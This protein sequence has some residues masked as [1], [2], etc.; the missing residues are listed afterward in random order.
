[1]GRM[2]EGDPRPA[3][4]PVLIGGTSPGDWNTE[5]C[6]CRLSTDG[7]S[8]HPHLSVG[9]WFPPKQGR[10]PGKRKAWMGFRKQDSHWEKGR[11]SRSRSQDAGMRPAR[12]APARSRG[13]HLAPPAALVQRAPPSDIPAPQSQPPSGLFQSQAR[14]CAPGGLYQDVCSSPRTANSL[15]TTLTSINKRPHRQ[16]VI[17]S[18][19]GVPHDKD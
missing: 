4:Q 17:Y 19:S 3:G 5:G 18:H 13:G 16:T 14:P 15:E 2:A 1:M 9:E 8:F 6:H 10:K 7:P 11:P 12:R